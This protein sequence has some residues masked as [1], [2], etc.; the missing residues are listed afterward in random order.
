MRKSWDNFMSKIEL[1]CVA[2]G[3]IFL[4]MPHYLI[5]KDLPD[6]SLDS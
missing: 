2:N 3:Y 1:L 5:Y 4:H 6:I